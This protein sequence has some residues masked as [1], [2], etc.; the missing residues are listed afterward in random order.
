MIFF[1]NVSYHIVSVSIHLVA[2]GTSF[3]VV[4]KN[5]NGL[6]CLCKHRSGIRSLMKNAS[7]MP[8]TRE[9][10]NEHITD[11][12]G[13]ARLCLLWSMNESVVRMRRIF[14]PISAFQLAKINEFFGGTAT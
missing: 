13:T 8:T 12:Q 9:G 2:T 11:Q 10:D 1:V 4:R 5:E 3:V 14:K 7:S 6:F